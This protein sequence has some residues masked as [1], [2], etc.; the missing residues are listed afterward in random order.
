MNPIARVQ[1]S[2]AAGCLEGTGEEEGA[3]VLP[4]TSRNG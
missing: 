2:M 4:T 1:L 3:E